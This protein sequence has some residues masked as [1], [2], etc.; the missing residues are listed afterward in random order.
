MRWLNL[1]SFRSISL[2]YVRR[3][4]ANTSAWFKHDLSMFNLWLAFF[5]WNAAVSISR[6]VS[7]QLKVGHPKWVGVKVKAKK[8]MV[9]IIIEA[10]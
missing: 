3:T 9:D 4:R 5:L 8:V 2:Q 10:D 1:F 6:M 7:R